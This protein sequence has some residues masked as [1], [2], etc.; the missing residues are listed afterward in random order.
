MATLILTDEEKAAGTWFELSD[1][2][3]GK[4]TKANGAAVL[5]VAEQLE[6][7]TAVA[8]GY[9]LIGQCVKQGAGSS[10]INIEEFS[11]SGVSYGDWEITVRRIF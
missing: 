5:N 11:Q 2:T 10:T 7:A 8:C 3:V 6:L 9:T 4:M 1:E